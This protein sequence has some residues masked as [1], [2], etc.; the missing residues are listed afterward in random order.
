MYQEQAEIYPPNITQPSLQNIAY[1][2]ANMI[3]GRGMT[4][5]SDALP[6]CCGHCYMRMGDPERYIQHYF[7]AVY[8][9]DAERMRCELCDIPIRL[10]RPVRDC[11]SC[12]GKLTEILAALIQRNESLEDYPGFLL[13]Y[14]TPLELLSTESSPRVSDAS[15]SE[16][17]SSTITPDAEETNP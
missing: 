8:T 17:S 2:L 4:Y 10:E 5:S 11:D 1:Y 13:E 7:H 3:C 12:T 16:E 9:N 6:R 15:D 14:V